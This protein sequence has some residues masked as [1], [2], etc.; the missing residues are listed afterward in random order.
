MAHVEGRWRSDSRLLRVIGMLMVMG[1]LLWT[2]VATAQGRGGVLRIGMTAADIAYTAGQPDQG[3][4]GFRFIGYPLY[5]AL[6][7]WDL[8]QGERLPDIAP[9][10]AESW[11]VD[12]DNVHKGALSC[13]VA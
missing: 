6:V 11:E 3:F 8:S 4:E 1:T 12:K 9:S 13:V 10:L 5:E 2:P 7:R